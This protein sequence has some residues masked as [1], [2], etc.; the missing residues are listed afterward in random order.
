MP[1][2]AHPMHGKL[3]KS[4]GKAVL[5]KNSNAGNFIHPINMKRD[6]LPGSS[7]PAKAGLDHRLI[8]KILQVAVALYLSVGQRN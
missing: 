7:F 8:M 1:A 4:K 3:H 2:G 6:S 5:W